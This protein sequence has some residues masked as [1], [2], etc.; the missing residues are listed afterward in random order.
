MSGPI[1]PAANGSGRSRLQR[2]ADWAATDRGLPLLALAL[3]LLGMAIVRLRLPTFSFTSLVLRYQELG[4]VKR[5]LLGTL[6]S[7]LLP[8]PI[9]SAG[10]TALWVLL[11]L[12]MALLLVR[13]TMALLICPERRTRLL[14][15]G[16]PALF[17]QLGYG[18]FFLDLF[19]LSCHLGALLLLRRRR[20]LD[21]LALMLLLAL[22]VLGV[23]FHELFLVAFLPLLIGVASLRSR[24]A[25]L[26]LTIAGGLLAV[27]MARYGAYEGGAAAL[28]ARLADHLAPPLEPAT[29]ELTSSLATNIHLTRRYL[30]EAGHLREAIP[31]ALYLVLLASATRPG[32]RRQVLLLLACLAPLALAPMAGDVSRW[33]GFACINIL[34]LA[35]MDLLPLRPPRWQALL[36]AAALLLGPIGVVASFPLIQSKLGPW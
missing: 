23:L 12:A 17:L 28:T 3:V 16:S 34:M 32:G 4:L 14:A 5:G 20:Q 19:T 1:S 18:F 10:G 25:A 22:V 13:L 2:L 30:L 36:L 27:L 9:S 21:G 15:L 26:L 11:G 7:P 8:L 29:F 24:R 33:L 35:L 31:G 6:L